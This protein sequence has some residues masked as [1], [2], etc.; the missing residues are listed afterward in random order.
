VKKSR[1]FGEPSLGGMFLRR[2][3]FLSSDRFAV[4]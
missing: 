4:R 3:S 2:G 1:T